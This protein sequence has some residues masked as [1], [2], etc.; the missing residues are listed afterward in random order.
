[1]K[2][3]TFEEFVE[4]Y[5]PVKNQIETNAPYDG[6][7]FDTFGEELTFVKA[8]DKFVWT[9][10]DSD[11]EESYIIPGYHFVNRLGYF[12]TELPFEDDVEVDLND[13]ITKDVAKAAFSLFFDR[14]GIQFS[15][16]VLD[17]A[18]SQDKY[19]VGEAKYKL[20]EVYEELKGEELDEEIIDDLHDT[21]YDYI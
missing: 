16:I 5:K 8:S 3:V 12:L 9:L 18:F 15:D 21:F 20:I 4:Q 1:M 10:V 6:L 14:W 7:M 13:Y 17:E 19:S 11:N 2:T